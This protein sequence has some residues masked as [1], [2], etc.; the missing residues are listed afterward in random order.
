MSLENSYKSKGTC[1]TR[2]SS[3]ITHYNSFGTN[4][5][6]VPNKPTSIVYIL[7]IYLWLWALSL[8]L[9]HLIAHIIILE[10]LYLWIFIDGLH[11]WWCLG[12]FN[13]MLCSVWIKFMSEMGIYFLLI[14]K[15]MQ[16]NPQHFIFCPG[17][18]IFFVIHIL[19]DQLNKA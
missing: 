1:I 8:I 16:H 15:F 6:V 3:C 13:K 4:Q 10:V 12:V 2:I 7:F 5:E 9:L 11:W 19:W 17:W 18:D 14:L